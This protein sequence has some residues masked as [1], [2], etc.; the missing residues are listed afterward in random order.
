VENAVRHGIEPK[1]DGGRVIVSARRMGGRVRLVV[2]DS[3][4]GIEAPLLAQIRAAAAG[5]GARPAAVPGEGGPGIGMA[6]LEERLAYRYG[7]RA[8]LAI[9]SRPGRGT[10]VRI[11]LPAA[12]GRDG[13]V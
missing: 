8:S 13:A 6:N 2:A 11:C 4:A 9:A 12:E 10:V 7:G 3:G 1:V 5:E